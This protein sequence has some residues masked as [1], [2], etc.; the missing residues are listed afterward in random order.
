M[1]LSKT[2]AKELLSRQLVQQLAKDPNQLSRLITSLNEEAVDM[3]DS[4]SIQR[5]KMRQ[6]P[7]SKSRSQ[8]SVVDGIC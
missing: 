7:N 2:A 4:L 5:K 3:D 1:A 6:T 8:E